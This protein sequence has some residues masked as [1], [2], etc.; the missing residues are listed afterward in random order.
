MHRRTGAE[1][2]VAFGRVS[3]H[4]YADWSPCQQWSI[5][6][7]IR[8]RLTDDLKLEIQPHTRLPLDRASDCSDQCRSRRPPS[9]AHG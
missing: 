8:L 4:E 7:S 2:H 3:A 1:R 5:R 9:H 6:H